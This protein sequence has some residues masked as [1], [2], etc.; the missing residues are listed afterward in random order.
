MTI[1]SVECAQRCG[2]T[3][4]VDRRWAGVA[5]GVGTAE[6][7]GRVHVAQMKIGKSYFASSFTILAN[8]SGTELLLG[9][10]ML[11]KHQC[12]IDLRENVLR[13]GDEKAPF[14]SEKDIPLHV[15]FDVS[16]EEMS[17][18]AGGRTGAG[19]SIPSTQE[20]LQRQLEQQLAEQQRRRTGSPTGS[21]SV[22]RNPAPSLPGTQGRVP[23]SSSVPLPATV[24]GRGGSSQLGGRSGQAPL[25]AP[26]PEG[27]INTLTN[28]GFTRQESMEALSITQ[29]NV[30]AAASYLFSRSSGF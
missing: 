30:E 12:C 1:M 23:S 5:R 19:R 15:R 21:P 6:I 17:R 4:L 2:M 8:N 22:V 3:R 14:L 7:A 18:G 13:I 29:G 10:D 28:L 16:E 20:L 26:W 11:K 9:L 25:P 24:G 27:S